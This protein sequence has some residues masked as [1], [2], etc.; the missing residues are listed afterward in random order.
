MLCDFR[1]KLHFNYGYKEKMLTEEFSPFPRTENAL[2]FSQE[3][4]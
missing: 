2:L 4:F 3:K 1:S